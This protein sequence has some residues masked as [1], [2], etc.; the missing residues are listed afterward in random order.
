MN[1]ATS[2]KII[3]QPATVQVVEVILV[4]S[5]AENTKVGPA[6]YYLEEVL[7]TATRGA[8]YLAFGSC[9]QDKYSILWLHAQGL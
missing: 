4:F 5:W 3:A 9:K 8:F 7:V 6:A 1:Y 2:S